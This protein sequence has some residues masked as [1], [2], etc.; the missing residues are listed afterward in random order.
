M[1][2]A[3][4]ALEVALLVEVQMKGD[5]RDRHEDCGTK[6]AE[7]RMRGESDQ[8]GRRGREETMYSG[9]LLRLEVGRE[10]KAVR[11]SIVYLQAEAHFRSFLHLEY[12]NRALSPYDGGWIRAGLCCLWRADDGGPDDKS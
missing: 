6:C 4:G 1:S 12:R 5:W 9:I 2:N 3:F 11:L 10:C 7:L 8:P